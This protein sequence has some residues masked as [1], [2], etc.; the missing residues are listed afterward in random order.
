MESYVWGIIIVLGL[1]LLFVF[2]Y[3]MNKRTPKP[4]GCELDAACKGCPITSCLKYEPKE[5]EK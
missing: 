3:I 4:E 2:A 5:E 1:M